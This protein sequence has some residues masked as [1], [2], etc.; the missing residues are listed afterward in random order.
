MTSIF[1]HGSEPLSPVREEFLCRLSNCNFPGYTIHHGIDAD[2][3]SFQSYYALVVRGHMRPGNSVLIHA[4]TGGVG[5]ASIAIALHMGC[6]VYTTVGSKEKRE[7]L[8][9][10]FPQLTDHHICN[11]RDTTFEQQ[12]LLETGGRGVDLVLNS[13]AEEKLQASVRCLAK[14]GRFLEIGKYD[15]SNNNPLGKFAALQ[16]QCL[17]HV[18][19]NSQIKSFIHMCK[20]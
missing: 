20:L 6:T 1:E 4:G 15:L 12:I 8:K 7:F 19:N 16:Y 18:L 10:T 9:K 5:Q 17:K 3:Y 11:S 13:L 14:D 2:T